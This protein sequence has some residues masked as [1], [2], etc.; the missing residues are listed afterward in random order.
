MSDKFDAF[1]E[2]FDNTK[3]D[4]FNDDVS[5]GVYDIPYM[6]NGEDEG[7][8]FFKRILDMFLG[9]STVVK[10]LIVAVPV[11]VVLVVVLVNMSTKPKVPDDIENPYYYSPKEYKFKLDEYVEGKVPYIKLQL[12][13]TF[14]NSFKST[15]KV[16][17]DAYYQIREDVV[18][19][20]KR[21]ISYKDLSGNDLKKRQKVYEESMD[22]INRLLGDPIVKEISE[23]IFETA[24]VGL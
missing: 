13:L 5:E 17:D 8:N 16:L 7:S 4:G 11:V 15:S 20:F 18:K 23:V 21:N 9:L 22:Y 19:R 6:D 14:D 3:D 12:E 10:A 2:D 24:L 1:E